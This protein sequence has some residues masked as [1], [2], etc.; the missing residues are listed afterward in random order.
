MFWI[1]DSK[2]AKN[3]EIFSTVTEFSFELNFYLDVPYSNGNSGEKNHD[4]YNFYDDHGKALHEQQSCGYSRQ[5]TTHHR[6]HHQ[7]NYLSEGRIQQNSLYR[8][9]S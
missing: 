5:P 6:H 8:N 7:R 1:L 2:I 3:V 4:D 9:V